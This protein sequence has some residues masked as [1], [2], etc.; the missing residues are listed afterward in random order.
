MKLR[1]NQKGFSPLILILLLLLLLI[2]GF[3]AWKVYD[4]N[5]KNDSGDPSSSSKTTS[6]KKSIPKTAEPTYVK[7]ISEIYRVALADG[8]VKGTCA[9]N[10]DI[11]FL[12]QSTDKLGKCQSEYF[13]TVAISKNS[14]N[15]GHN[16]EYYTADDA[17]ASVTYVAITIDGVPGYRVSY[18]VATENEL[19]TPAVGT[20]IVQY[21]LY[22]GTSTF[23]ISYS[24][25][26]GDPDLTAE[27]QI[28]ADSFDKL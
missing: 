4:T 3:A 11:L 24:R 22:D 7:P 2:V 16:E 25:A 12:A 5:K 23:T 8:W 28:I 10:P 6:A 9:D 1:K 27:V 14:G 18:T 15:T 20:K 13:G 17:Y 19:G 21:V 26:S